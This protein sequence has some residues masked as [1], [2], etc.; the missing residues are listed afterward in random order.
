MS[1]AQQ[2]VYVGLCLVVLGVAV[3]LI[4]KDFA[5]CTQLVKQ[6]K[7]HVFKNNFSIFRLLRLFDKSNCTTLYIQ[8]FTVIVSLD[9]RLLHTDHCH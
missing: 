1:S 7:L 4:A 8:L 5:P 2:L 3:I 6:A 9:T